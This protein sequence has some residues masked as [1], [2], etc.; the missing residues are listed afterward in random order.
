MDDPFLS[1]DLDDL[2]LGAFA[3]T[4]EYDDLIVFAD[5]K[6]SNTQLLAKIL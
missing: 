4:S 3:G 1:V 2:S 6:G 5:G